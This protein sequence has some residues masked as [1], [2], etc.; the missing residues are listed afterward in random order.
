MYF[1]GELGTK[2]VQPQQEAITGMMKWILIERESGSRKQTTHEVC[3]DG[4]FRT[5]YALESTFWHRLPRMSLPPKQT[6]TSCKPMCGGEKNPV[7][8]VIESAPQGG[9]VTSCQIDTTV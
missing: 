9:S 7:A 1:Q 8:H 5:P 4:E 3:C 2:Q 6:A